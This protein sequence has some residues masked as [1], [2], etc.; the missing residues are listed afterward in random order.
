MLSYIAEL[1]SFAKFNEF[2]EEYRARLLRINDRENHM[3]MEALVQHVNEDSF[4]EQLNVQ[5]KRDVL[6][7]LVTNAELFERGSAQYH[8]VLHVSDKYLE[9]IENIP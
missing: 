3:F 1:N 5:E 2:L 6:E 8:T 7:T 9:A 4:L